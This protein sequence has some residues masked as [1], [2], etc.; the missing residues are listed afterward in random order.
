MRINHLVLLA[1]AILGISGCAEKEKRE[2]LS[3]KSVIQYQ[4]AHDAYLKGDLIVALTFALKAE[5]MSPKAAETKNLLG[6]I[7]FQQEKY[8]EAEAKFLKAAELDPKMSE[9]FTN[10]GSLYY[11]MKRFPEAMVA[12][13]HALENPL[14]LYPERIHNN[15]GLVYEAMNKVED[16]VFEYRRSIELDKTFFLPRQNLGRLYFEKEHFD[17]AKPV[18]KEAVKLCSECSEARYFLG[19]ILMKENKTAEALKIF[20]EGADVDPSGYYGEMCKKFIATE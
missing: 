18:L 10:L 6:L 8:P 13:D 2:A 3:E 4:F 15:R 14:Y 1:L 11:E 12:L 19:S 5:E 16:A 9:V 17:L 20:K 7:Y